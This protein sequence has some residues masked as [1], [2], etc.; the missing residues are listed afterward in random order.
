MSGNEGPYRYKSND[1]LLLMWV[2]RTLRLF[3]LK[4]EGS[5]DE[6]DRCTHSLTLIQAEI[7]H[8]GLKVKFNDQTGIYEIMSA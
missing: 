2:S 6:F 5:K 4:A 3:F 1:N 8:R 7:T